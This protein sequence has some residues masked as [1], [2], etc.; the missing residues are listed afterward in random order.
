[1]NAA[2][3]RFRTEYAAHRAS[4]GRAHAGD[5]LRSLPYL[6][7]GPLARQWA[8]RARSFEVLMEEVVRPLAAQA[9]GPLRVLDLG[10]GNGWLSYRLAREG[11]HC[12][13]IDIRDDHVDG[14]GAAE[15][16]R[17]V[18]HFDRLVASF[19]TLPL[20][21]HSA[22]LAVF[23]ASL[24]YAI[25]LGK[26]LAEAMRCLRPVGCVAIVDS[27][28]YRE[29]GDGEAMVREKRRTPGLVAL[30]GVE[31]LTVDRLA[32]ASGLVWRRHR[33]RY[34]VWYELR[35]LVAAL[36]GARKPSRFDVWTAQVP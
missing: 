14:L 15:E 24:H 5:E 17:R 33:V 21:P 28:F 1:M 7:S 22:D 32:R 16:L 11:H 6:A 18:A 12:T 10:A 13:A 4:E 30:D 3:D 27:P 29:A 26:T 25:D 19:E 36:R 2:V 34:P 23:N 8:V 9:N 20:P 31:F 35:P